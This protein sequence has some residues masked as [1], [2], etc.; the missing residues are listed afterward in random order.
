MPYFVSFRKEY[1][2]RMIAL[3]VIEMHHRV[4]VIKYSLGLLKNGQ[5]DL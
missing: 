3:P 4:I 5:M 2:G 1:K